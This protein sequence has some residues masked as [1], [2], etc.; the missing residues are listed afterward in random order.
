MKSSFW[1]KLAS[2][3]EL[4]DPE[5]CH[6]KGDGTGR[7]MG[8]CAFNGMPKCPRI[9]IDCLKVNQRRNTGVGIRVGGTILTLG[10]PQSIKWLLA[11]ECG[12][13]GPQPPPQ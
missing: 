1:L 4:C 12:L 11:T 5:H 7:E 2:Q 10:P 8:H 6:E 13:S 9:F 3:K